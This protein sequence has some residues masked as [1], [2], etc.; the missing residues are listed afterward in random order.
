MMRMRSIAADTPVFTSA[1][2][3]AG[4]PTED[5][6]EGGGSFFVFDEDGQVV[7]FGGL[8]IYGVDVLL[9]SAVVLPE[10]R[11]HGFGRAIVEALLAR[12]YVDGARRAWLLTLTAEQFFTQLGFV[13]AER[14]EAPKSI[15]A[16]KQATALCVSA[17]LLTRALAAHG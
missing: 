13:Q 4:L 14:A 1:L 3:A 15:L 10:A 5:L 2:R 9:R 17:P 8:E 7:G 12:A 6:T 11:G 16:T